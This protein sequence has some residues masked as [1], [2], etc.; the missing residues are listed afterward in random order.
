MMAFA[1]TDKALLVFSIKALPFMAFIIIQLFQDTGRR[2]LVAQMG[3]GFC[4]F[5]FPLSPPCCCSCFNLNWLQIGNFCL[6]EH[7][8]HDTKLC[9]RN[10]GL[11][12]LCYS[13]PSFSLMYCFFFLKAS[14]TRRKISQESH[15]IPAG[16][17]F[18]L[19]FTFASFKQKDFKKNSFAIQ[20]QVTFWILLLLEELYS[21]PLYEMLEGI[22]AHDSGMLALYSFPPWPLDQRI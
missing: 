14:T 19:H 15:A 12:L 18:H 2:A 4:F 13:N 21:M 5:N 10:T 11:N 16:E 9:M 7:Q 6:S 17:Y 20:I 22:L 1:T 8:W 3:A